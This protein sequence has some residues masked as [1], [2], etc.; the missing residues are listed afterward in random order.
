MSKCTP[1]KQ[2]PLLPAW[3][4]ACWIFCSTRTTWNWGSCRCWVCRRKWTRIW[5]GDGG[6]GQPVALLSPI[7]RPCCRWI[8]SSSSSW[9]QRG[10]STTVYSR[11]RSR[12]CQSGAWNWRTLR[13]TPAVRPKKL[14]RHI[15][16][17][18]IMPRIMTWTW[19]GAVPRG[20]IRIRFSCPVTRVE[21]LLRP[22]HS[23]R[24]PGRT[25]HRTVRS[26]IESTLGRN[27]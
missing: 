23:P 1:P 13:T 27:L 15:T 2:A 3:T 22:K 26:T 9:M 8:S 19:T 6:K 21:N 5:N 20:Y 16:P 11:A 17:Y 4:R 24:T 12:A 18:W 14:P 25:W 10:D 7:I